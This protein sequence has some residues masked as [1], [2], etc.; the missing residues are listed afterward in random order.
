MKP[1]TCHFC[2]LTHESPRSE[3][4]HRGTGECVDTAACAARVAEAEVETLRARVA[5]LERAK[6][7]DDLA[8]EHLKELYAASYE[9]V[10]ELERELHATRD[11]HM[12]MTRRLLQTER[13]R[14]EARAEVE[15]LTRRV[16]M[17]E[18][19]RSMEHGDAITRAER[20]EAEA[21]RLR[22]A[23]CVTLEALDGDTCAGCG[24]ELSRCDT[25]CAESAWWRD[26]RAALAGEVKP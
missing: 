25:E 7:S 5:E 22:D 9:R 20:A 24:F 3:V 21:A 26:A 23:L 1:V 17:L 8:W 6:A 13:E 16:S 19:S 14:D 10:A 11:A 2:G 12:V 18:H 15:R 4:V